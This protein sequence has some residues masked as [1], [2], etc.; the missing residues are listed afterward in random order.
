MDSLHW[1]DILCISS[2]F[3]SGFSPPTPPPTIAVPCSAPC[4]SIDGISDSLKLIWTT[5]SAALSYKSLGSAAAV[6]V[7]WWVAELIHRFFGLSAFLPGSGRPSRGIISRASCTG[8]LP[9]DCLSFQVGTPDYFSCSSF[10]P[11]VWEH[12]HQ[13]THTQHQL[14]MASPSL[15]DAAGKLLQVLKYFSVYDYAKQ[16]AAT[17]CPLFYRC[18]CCSVMSDSLRPHGL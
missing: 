10:V 8:H 18:C 9:C 7:V 5:Y 3:N 15:E 13:Q 16:R 17:S 2:R 1:P 14:Y 6:S 11:G 12:G 4:L